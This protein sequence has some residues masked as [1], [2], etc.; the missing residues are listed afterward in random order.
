MTS[1]SATPTPGTQPP[2]DPDAL[3]AEIAETRADLGDSVDAL[4]AKANLRARAKAGVAERRARAR[5]AAAR[6]TISLRAQTGNLRAK[7]GPT[8]QQGRVY[9]VKAKQ[10]A[11]GTDTRT[12]AASGVGAGAV[13][14]LLAVLVGARRRRRAAQTPWYRRAR[15]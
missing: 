10:T 3:R 11:A 14:V 2:A 1:T 8:L 12:R 4:A 15:R 5:Q 9:A 6:T 7:T 13:A